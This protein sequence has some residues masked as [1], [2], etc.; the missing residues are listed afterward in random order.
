MK[1]SLLYFF[2]FASLNLTAQKTPAF[3]VVPLGVKGGIDESNLSSYM[4]APAGTNDYVCLDAGTVHT[5]IERAIASK[6]FKATTDEVLKNYIKGYFISHAHL[7]HVAGLI[8]VSPEDSNKTVYAL[9][10]CM[11]ILED[12]YFNGDAWANFGDEGKSFHLKKYH[13]QTLKAEEETPVNNTTLQVT[14]F[15]LS[16]AN[17]YESSAFLLHNK[18]DYVLYL[19]DTGA[20]S[21]EKSNKL[22]L[23]WQTVAPLVKK[24]KLKGIFIEVSFPDEQPENK[25]FGHLTPKLFMKEMQ[26]L[27]NLTG[28]KA[29][30]NVPIIITHVKPPTAHIIQLKK[31][32]KLANNLGLNL[33]FPQQGKEFAL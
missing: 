24:H 9:P 21:I 1:K 5:G 25:L 2:I 26:A 7:D 17:P 23:L 28:K 4:V 31:Q 16:H 32:L 19:G 33:I 8:I 27:S 20:D 30:K 15:A 29:I 10:S 18:D 11:K 14:A 13:F 22:L 6:A 12:N 3:R